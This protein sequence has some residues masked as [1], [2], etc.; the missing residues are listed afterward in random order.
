[1]DFARLYLST[2][3]AAHFVLRA[4]RNLKFR[5]RYS[6][7]ADRSTGVYCDQTI[8][9]AVPH[10]ADLYPDPLRRVRSHDPEDGKQ[11]TLLSNHFDLPALTIAELYRCRWQ[12]ELFFKWIKRHLRIKA[13]YGTSANAVK[14]QIW[15]AIS[16]Y[17]HRHPE[18]ATRDRA[19]PLHLATD[20]QR[21]A[22]REGRDLPSTYEHDLHSS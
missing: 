5:R 8:L 13:F 3:C 17:A 2:R 20:A 7:K 22:V 11:I 21:H 4:K 14:T 16:V 10:S 18:E 19:Q 9:L 15:I 1:V 6:Q 12:V